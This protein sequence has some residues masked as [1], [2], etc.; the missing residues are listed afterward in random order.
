MPS[1]RRVSACRPVYPL[2][3]KILLCDETGRLRIQLWMLLGVGVLDIP[4]TTGTQDCCR[5]PHPGDDRIGGSMNESIEWYWLWRPRD[6]VKQLRHDRAEDRLWILL[7]LPKYGTDAVSSNTATFPM[8]TASSVRKQAATRSPMTLQSERW[9]P[10]A[11]MNT[12]PLTRRCDSCGLELHRKVSYPILDVYVC[13][14]VHCM[15]RAFIA[16]ISKLEPSERERIGRRIQDLQCAAIRHHQMAKAYGAHT[17][18]WLHNNWEGANITL[19]LL[20]KKPMKFTA[21]ISILHVFLS[22]LRNALFPKTQNI[23]SEGFA[24]LWWVIAIIWGISFVSFIFFYSVEK[25]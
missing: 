16:N 17:M 14:T 12:A 5:T 15:S 21:S 18:I 2:G 25:E 13:P 4:Y 8:N 11:T 7:G 20:K 10:M 22:C 19:P 24:W 6:F 1:L 3:G 23:F 9:K